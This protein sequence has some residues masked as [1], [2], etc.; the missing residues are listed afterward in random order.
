MRS[1]DSP[2]NCFRHRFKC[3]DAFE[4]LQGPETGSHQHLLLLFLLIRAH[5]SGH[6]AEP[7]IDIGGRPSEAPGER[8]RQ[9]GGREPHV[10]DVD[11]FADGRS[12][13]GLGEKD[14]EVLQAGAARVFNGPGETACTLM[15]LSPSS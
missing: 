1:C 14:V 15:C 8:G 10:V 4:L 13:D 5:P 3:D 6:D 11:Q 2:R 9:K 7:A 12:L